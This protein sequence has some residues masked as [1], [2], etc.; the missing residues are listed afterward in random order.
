MITDEEKDKYTTT[1]Y[2]TDYIV[3]GL[4]SFSPL[5]HAPFQQE[6]LRPLL[7]LPGAVARVLLPVLRRDALPRRALT[8]WQQLRP[9][10]EH[11]RPLPAWH[12]PLLRIR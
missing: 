1:D 9:P 7:A 11:A 5:P 4:P 2:T 6:P 10:D 12:A 8:L 3:H